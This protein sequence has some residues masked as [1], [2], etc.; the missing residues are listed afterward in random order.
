V[1]TN[2]PGKMKFDIFLIG[3]S[4]T[5]LNRLQFNTQTNATTTQGFGK[6]EVILA[7]GG[8]PIP[9]GQYMVYIAESGEQDASVKESL[10]SFQPSR[11]QKNIPAQIP[12]GAKFVVNKVFFIGGERDQTYL[13]RLKAFHDKIK[14]GAEKEMG[15]LKQYTETLGT[16]L[17]TL[18]SDFQ[19]IFNAKKPTAAMKNAWKKDIGTWTQISTQLDQTVQTWSK[20]TLQNEFFYGKVYDLVKSNYAAM[21]ALFALE[22]TWVEKPSDKSA[23]E[24]QHGKLL[25]DARESSGILKQK[26][27]LV[28][29]APKTPSGLPTREGL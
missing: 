1:S 26:L 27:E 3:S 9:K 8:Q 20:E 7:D 23:F 17:S 6:S 18:T 13:T 24:I 10:A 5:L 12:N 25:S 2:L 14:Q 19:K 11:P 15:E 21:K 4:E 16:Q 29:K 28:E 22:A